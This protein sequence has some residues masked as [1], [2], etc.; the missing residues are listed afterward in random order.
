MTDISKP[1]ARKLAFANRKGAYGQGHDKQACASLTGFL[2]SGFRFKV[3]AAYMPIQTE[4]SPIETMVEL[5]NLGKTVCIPVIDA[6]GKPLK[7]GRW[8]PNVKLIK[9]PFGAAIP[10]IEDFVTPD[11][12]ITPLVAYD[13]QGY[14]LGYGGGF[15]DRTFELLRHDRPTPAIGFAYSAQELPQVPTEPTDIR[16]D[17]M[18][19]EKGVLSF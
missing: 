18:V 6:S 4:I 10:A 17:H 11:I 8:T 7:F 13:A 1:D 3:I 16:L 19:S 14:R 5:H 2:R 15:Y 12:L 9:G